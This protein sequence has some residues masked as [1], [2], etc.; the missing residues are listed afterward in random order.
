MGVPHKELTALLQ[1]VAWDTMQAEP[2]SGLQKQ[3]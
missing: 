3:L 2:L 1:Q